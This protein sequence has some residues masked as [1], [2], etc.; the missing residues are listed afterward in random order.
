MF[1]FGAQEIIVILMLLVIIFGPLWLTVF[2]RKKYPQREW[3]GII[4]A[5]VFAPVG[6]FYL[7]GAIWYTIGLFV[8]YLIIKSITEISAVSWLATCFFS[9]LLMYYRFSKLESGKMLK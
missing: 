3:L 2:L 8:I 9:S 6:Q 4:L 1:G 7:D 5:F